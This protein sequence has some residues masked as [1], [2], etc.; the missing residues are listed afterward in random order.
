MPIFINYGRGIKKPSKIIKGTDIEDPSIIEQLEDF[1]RLDSC[2]I[3][4]VE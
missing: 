1:T 2:V 3:L 4:V